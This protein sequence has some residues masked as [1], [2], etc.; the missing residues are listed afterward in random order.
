M[1]KFNYLYTDP[2][3]SANGHT[4]YG[5]Y[6]GDSEFQTDSTKIENK[7]SHGLSQTKEVHFKSFFP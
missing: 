3:A 2:S 5:I 4:P 6:D 7:L 1:S